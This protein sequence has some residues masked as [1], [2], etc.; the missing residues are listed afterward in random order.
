LVAI[1]GAM[2]GRLGC[3]ALGAI[4]VVMLAALGG[5]AV[6]A[7]CVGFALYR[8]SASPLAPSATWRDGRITEIHRCARPRD[9]A[10]LLACAALHCQAAVA[11]GLPEPRAARIS[12]AARV[13]EI[14][15]RYLRFV[16]TIEAVAGIAVPRGYECLVEGLSVASLRLIQ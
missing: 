14:D 13:P 4:R 16:G 3:G 9:A 15:T 8:P 2:T 11:D 10:T 5:V 1:R 6:A 12:S 7:A